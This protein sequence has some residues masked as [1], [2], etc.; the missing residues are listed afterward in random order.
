MRE[1]G[2]EGGR[3]GERVYY[4]GGGYM[5]EGGRGGEGERESVCVWCMC[6]FVNVCVT[7]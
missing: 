2:R 5:R 4:N 6:V 7:T 1:K 3:E